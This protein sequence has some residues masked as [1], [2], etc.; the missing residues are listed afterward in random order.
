MRKKYGF[1]DLDGTLLNHVKKIS[2]KNLTSLEKF[3]NNDGEIVICT[4]RWPVSASIFSSQISN[5]TKKQNP[6]LISLNGAYIQ[7]LKTNEL[8]SSSSIEESVFEKL[9]ETQRKFSSFMWIYSK[10]GIEN[11]IIFSY[12]IPLK[13]I[14]SKFNYGIVRDY[15]EIKYKNDPKY[16]VLFFSLST[17]KISKIYKWLSQNFS[18]ILSII[19]TSRR[20]IEITPLGIDK[21]FGVKTIKKLN[22]LNLNQIYAFGDSG[23]DVAMFEQS[24]FRFSFGHKNKKLDELANFSLNTNKKISNVINKLSDIENNLVFDMSKKIYLNIEL[25]SNNFNV[26]NFTKYWY[27]WNYLINQKELTINSSFYP[28]W[29]NKIILKNFLINKNLFIWSNNRNS[30]YSEK[31]EEFIFAKSFSDT[32]I[33]KIKNFFEKNSNFIKL[34]I[35]ENTKG[36][37]Y[38]IYENEEILN[39]FLWSNK[40]NKNVF[41]F[42]KN[43]NLFDVKKEFKNILSVSFFNIFPKDLEVDFKVSKQGR[44]FHVLNKS[45][46]IEK[47]NNNIEFLIN[48]SV[49]ESKDFDLLNEY[50]KKISK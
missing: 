10:Y 32:Q 8:I 43:K 50:F 16:K 3:T 21:G 47:Q 2:K 34:F 49:D 26:I 17:N 30:V 20:T 48:S 19:K 22:K 6:Y 25:V 5:F 40:I 42:L 11:K 7:N 37:T 46:N 18:Q 36:K 35:F 33:E 1:I 41:D 27:F 38:L 12:K 9:L 23:N 4:G 24:G 31:E 44:V 39:S 45:T 15:D 29:S 28:N 14:V 13:K